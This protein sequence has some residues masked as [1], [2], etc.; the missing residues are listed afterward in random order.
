[1]IGLAL[2]LTLFIMWPTFTTIND[3]AFQPLD[4]GEITQEEALDITEDAFREFMYGQTQT[5][6]L[7]LFCE[8]ADITYDDYDDVP[9][10]VI[11]PSFILSELR[12]AFIIGFLIYIPFIVIDM[13]VGTDGDGYDDAAADDD[14][15][16]V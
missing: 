15:H 5:K 13:V 7:N 9:F 10:R 11:V 6:D 4:R 8:I 12:T 1:M 14:L 2:F 16:A 3:D